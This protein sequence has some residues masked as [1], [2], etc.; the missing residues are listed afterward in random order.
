MPS[1]VT[2][3]NMATAATTG[4]AVVDPW[5]AMLVGL[6]AIIIIVI[7]MEIAKKMGKKL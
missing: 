4:T 7:L 6:T 5:Y 1:A 3:L 2:T